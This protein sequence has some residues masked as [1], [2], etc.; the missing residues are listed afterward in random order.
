[1]FPIVLICL[2]RVVSVLGRAQ[3]LHPLP[4]AA[5]LNKGT[6]P[7]ASRVCGKEISH[8]R[9]A[10]SPL[11]EKVCPTELSSFTLNDPFLSG[12]ER[13]KFLYFAAQSPD[14]GAHEHYWL[15]YWYKKWTGNS[16]PAEI[17]QLGFTHAL[18][19]YLM[20]RVEGAIPDSDEVLAFEMEFNEKYKESKVFKDAQ[21]PRFTYELTQ[22]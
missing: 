12:L 22:L 16:E 21:T 19:D 20:D 17:A 4:A 13:L 7:P 5:R 15:A 1:M 9:V 2:F 10:G 14:A 8:P 6:E 18:L 11:R 3:I